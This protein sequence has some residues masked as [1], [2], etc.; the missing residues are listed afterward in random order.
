M[1]TIKSIFA[2]LFLTILTANA[3]EREQLSVPLTD[4]TKEGKLNINLVTGSIKVLGYAGKE[5]MID[6]MV[7]DDANDD[8][9][10]P[11]NR[12][13]GMKKI[14]SNKGFEITAR[15]KANQVYVGVN[16]PNLKVNFTIKV[17]LKFDLKVGTVNNGDIYIE[18]VNGNHEVSNVNGEIKM[19]NIAGSVSANTINEDVVVNFT[20]ITPNTPMAFTTLNGK[21]DITFPATLKAN[22]KLRTDQ[23]EIYTD[24]D[25][26]V[27]KTPAKINQ[28]NDKEKGVYKIKKDD[29]TYGKINGGG[30]EIM[31]KTMNGDV[32][33]RKV[34]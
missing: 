33:I 23:G 4:P 9:H 2:I 24:F 21:L 20:S 12:P 14:S 29:W 7:E 32:V 31:M 3:Q 11:K 5:V 28:T 19:K 26:D 25:I 17:P 13:D 1:K 15:E 10:R 16:N 6:A 22:V 27:D 30:P 18:N 34:K 8:N